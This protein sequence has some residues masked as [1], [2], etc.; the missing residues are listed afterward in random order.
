[1][2]NQDLF[3]VTFPTEQKGW[4]CGRWGMV[5]HTED[6]GENWVR[7]PSGTDYVLT[8]ICFSDPQNGWAVGEEGVIIHT[9]DG[10]RSWVK[11][12][13]PKGYFLEGV[14]FATDQ[15]G[16]AVTEWTTI[17]YTEDEGDNWEVQFKGEDYI[18][19][20]VSFCDELNG[21]A[22]GEYG[23]IYHTSDGGRNW[24]HQAGFFEFADDAFELRGGNTLFDVYAVDPTSA[25]VV[26][27]DG[28]IGRTL[29][30][31][32]TWERV[33]CDFEM[34]QLFGVCSDA[35]GSTVLI[36]GK[37]WLIAS[38]DRGKH[39]MIPEIDPPIIYGWL[40]G[41]ARRGARGFVAVGKEGWIYLSDDRAMSWKRAMDAKGTE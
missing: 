4:A 12:N 26:G 41:I 40:Y 10:G 9:K 23:F 33:K 34:T 3:S 22:A 15:K 16:W 6:G 18:L 36:G 30:G 28:Y 5:L 17:L 39:F 29:D 14:C 8:S 19:K 11:Q 31:G 21:W 2:I 1:V 38:A 20:A 37:G 13:C 24:E 27:I 25:W 7:Q 35:E 32:K